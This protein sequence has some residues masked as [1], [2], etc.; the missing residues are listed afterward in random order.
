MEN[1]GGLGSAGAHF[2]KVTFGDEIMVPDDTLHSRFSQLSLAVA[3]DSGWYDV[4]FLDG[5]EY[6]Y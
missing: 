6:T 3:A 4:N 2:E 1:G 5:D